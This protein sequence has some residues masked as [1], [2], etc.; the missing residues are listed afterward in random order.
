MIDTAFLCATDDMTT[1]TDDH[2][3]HQHPTPTTTT[4]DGRRAL[5]PPLRPEKRIRGSILEAEVEYRGQDVVVVEEK[6]VC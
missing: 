5:V 1:T 2:H 6:G 4:D 3:H